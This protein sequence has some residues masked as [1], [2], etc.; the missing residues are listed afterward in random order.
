M[1]SQ[2]KGA[3]AR[4]AAPL[5]AGLYLEMRD[6]HGAFGEQGSLTVEW[7]ME[8]VKKSTSFIPCSRPFCPSDLPVALEK[9]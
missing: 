1:Y 3:F 9:R 6:L 4:E 8:I 5:F 7:K 2:V